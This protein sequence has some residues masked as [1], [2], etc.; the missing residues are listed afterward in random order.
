[1]HDLTLENLQFIDPL[2]IAIMFREAE[3]NNL[4]LAEEW[5][6]VVRENDKLNLWYALQSLYRKRNSLP[7]DKLPVLLWSH[8]L[9][10]AWH[11]NHS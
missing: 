5:F 11:Q 1:M 8:D 4:Q 2:P 6:D 3:L 10:K 7:P 9:V